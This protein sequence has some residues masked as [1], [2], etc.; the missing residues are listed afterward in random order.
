M[1]FVRASALRIAKEVEAE[2]FSDKRGLQAARGMVGQCFS[3]RNLEA[4]A[5]RHVARKQCPVGQK[6]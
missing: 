2:H 5:G 3:T 4:L 6:Y 1:C